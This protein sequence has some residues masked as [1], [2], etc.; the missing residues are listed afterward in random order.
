MSIHIKCGIC[1]CEVT[2]TD[3]KTKTITKFSCP[4]CYSEL[5]SKYLDK[6]KE[7]MKLLSELEHV[8]RPVGRP[9]GGAIL[10]KLFTVRVTS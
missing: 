1:G 4:A 10:G 8:P 5:P 6:A 9:G 3:K 2:I 7:C